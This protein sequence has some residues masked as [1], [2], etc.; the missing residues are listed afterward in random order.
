MKLIN[1]LIY[2][3]GPKGIGPTEIR[4]RVEG[5]RVPRDSHYTIGPA[6]DSLT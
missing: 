6:T 3:F 4:T 5:F 1:N 2:D